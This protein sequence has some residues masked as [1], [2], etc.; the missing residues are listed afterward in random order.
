MSNCYPPVSVKG[1]LQQ[2]FPWSLEQPSGV[3]V[4]FIFWWE[5]WRHEVVKPLAW[6]LCSS[7]LT[8]HCFHLLYLRG[9]VDFPPSL[10]NISLLSVDMHICPLPLFFSLVNQK[11][12]GN[13]I[14]LK[15]T[16]PH[17]CAL[18]ICEHFLEGD[19]SIFTI[20]AIPSHKIQSELMFQKILLDCYHLKINCYL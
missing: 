9:K 4:R 6:S 11:C 3:G 1:A 8:L 20:I 14:M 5:K 16:I 15:G 10:P 2:Y 19:I 17:N 7:P 13:T 12:S 18:R